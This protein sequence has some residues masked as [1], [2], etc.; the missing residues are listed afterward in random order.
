MILIGR[1]IRHKVANTRTGQMRL[2]WI[3]S[4]PGLE[5]WFRPLGRPKLPG[6]TRAPVFGR[7]AD[8]AKVEARQR[9]IRGT[10]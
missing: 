7:P 4:P 2:L 1:G 8:I 10:E 6:D 9:F 5:D 3:I